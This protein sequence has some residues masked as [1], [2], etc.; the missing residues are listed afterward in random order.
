MG[1][2]SMIALIFLLKMTIELLVIQTVIF[3]EILTQQ[4]KKL[5]HPVSLSNIFSIFKRTDFCI[6][7]LCG[8]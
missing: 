5:M 7:V 3:L 4:N 6:N 2:F 1:I 8:F